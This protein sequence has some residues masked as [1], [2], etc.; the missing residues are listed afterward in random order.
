MGHG[1]ETPRQK[2]IGMMYLVL[3]ALL[4]LNVS[5]EVLNAFILVDKSLGKTADN[6]QIKNEE[7]Y[8]SFEK[9]MADPKTAASVKPIKE[10]ADKVK[11][12][13]QTLVDTLYNFKVMMVKKADGP[14]SPYIKE[15]GE[16][17]F[18]PTVIQKKDEN[19][20]PSEVMILNEGGKR[21]KEMINTYRNDL[22]ALIEDTARYSGLISSLNKTLST[23]DGINNE[24][25]PIG[26][27]EQTFH[28]LPLAGATTMLSKIQADIRNAESD[29]LNYLKSRIGA[30]DFKFNKIE[31]IVNS[32]TNYVLKGEKYSAEVFIAASDSTVEPE[33]LVGGSKLPIKDGK[34][35]YTGSTGSVG[36]KKWGGVI[37]LENPATKEIK[38]YKFESEY[39]V[40]EPSVVVSPTKMNVFYLGVQNPV[41]VSASGIP[42]DKLR[43]SID[44]GSITKSGNDYMVKVRRP[45]KAIIS[46]S[47]DIG[48]SVRSMGKREFRV[49]RIPD[50]VAEVGGVSGGSIRKTVLIAQPAIRA[51]LKNFDFDLNFAITGFKVSVIVKG[52]E[53]TESTRSSRF[54]SKQKALIKRVNPGS[55]VYIEDI[56]ARGPDGSVRDLPPIIVKLK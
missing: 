16:H 21:L 46:I 19:N 44:N 36:F 4:A 41:A 45:G 12:L 17:Q 43:V 14:L 23:E 1:K 49:K 33:I 35:I 20:I 10:L 32:P 40:G 26:W 53:V 51:V 18:D 5:A 29:M 13:S 2:M 47:A 34:G 31:A 11:G 39:Q 50:P 9:Q 25:A 30:D 22:I 6:L 7:V 56:K 15:G 48:G 8:G 28:H 55:K 24:G 42:A 52:Y 37:R 54:T 3:T 38:E 27:E